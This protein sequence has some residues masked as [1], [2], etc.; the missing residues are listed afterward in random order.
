MILSM[1]NLSVSA[2][3]M[4]CPNWAEFIRRFYDLK[5]V[6][7]MLYKK[8]KMFE[9]Q[10]D[11]QKSSFQISLCVA[12]VSQNGRNRWKSSDVTNSN[13]A[14][15]V[16][17]FKI[18]KIY[19]YWTLQCSFRHTKICKNSREIIFN[20]K[21]IWNHTQNNLKL[22]FKIKFWH[23]TKVCRNSQT[24]RLADEAPTAGPFPFTFVR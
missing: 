12:D 7:G 17:T 9:I 5:K 6:I 1:F 4:P 13:R 18:K 3:L 2:T 24:K 11:F 19:S 14:S 21:K 20:R 10:A 8:L 23:F 16:C 22:R 15:E